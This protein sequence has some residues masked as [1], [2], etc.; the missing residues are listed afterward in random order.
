MCQSRPF[1]WDASST[2]STPGQNL[3]KVAGFRQGVEAQY[4]T[5]LAQVVAVTT[6]ANLFGVGSETNSLP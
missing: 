4:A 2:S 1:V 5:N 3:R 6:Q